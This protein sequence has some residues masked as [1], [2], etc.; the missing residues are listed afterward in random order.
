MRFIHGILLLAK[1]LE[2]SLQYVLNMYFEPK[3]VF[4]TNKMFGFLETH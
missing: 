2:L 1:I 4:N 3:L